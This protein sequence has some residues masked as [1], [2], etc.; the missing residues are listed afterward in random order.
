MP[1]MSGMPGMAG[2][3][4]MMSEEDMAALQNAQAVA[5]SKLYLTQMIKHHQG[6]ISMAQDEI[7]DGQYPAATAMAHAI[8]TGQQ[9]EID[10]MNKILA[11]L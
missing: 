7:K 1:G 10:T 9:Q 3:D 4:G 5:A 8:V 6:A 2:M 11:S